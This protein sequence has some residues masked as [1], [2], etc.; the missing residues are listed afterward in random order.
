[1]T[2]GAGT[3]VAGGH[4]LIAESDA[5]LGPG[6]IPSIAKRSIIRYSK[7]LGSVMENVFRCLALSSPRLI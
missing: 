5:R 7:Q 4:I 2:T 1:M 3:V 6:K